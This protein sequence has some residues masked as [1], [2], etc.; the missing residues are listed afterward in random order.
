MSL[1]GATPDSSY[2][3]IIQFNI[4]RVQS[5]GFLC[6]LPLQSNLSVSASLSP[7]RVSPFI[8]AEAVVKVLSVIRR[9]LSVK[10]LGVMNVLWLPCCN[11]NVMK[12]ETGVQMVERWVEN[13]TRKNDGQSSGRQ[14]SSHVVYC[15]VHSILGIFSGIVRYNTDTLDS[16]MAGATI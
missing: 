11:T 10:C 16:L 12:C 5:S 15:T 14:R 9:I 2:Q 8:L 13:W 3:S 6:L 4:K 7:M 1:C